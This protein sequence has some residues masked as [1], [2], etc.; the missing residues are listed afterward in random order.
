MSAGKRTPGPWIAGDS[1]VFAGP[2]M[3]SGERFQVCAASHIIMGNTPRDERTKADMAF[4]VEA[5]NSHDSLVS[6]LKGQCAELDETAAQVVTLRSQRDALAESLRFC[7]KALEVEAPI[8]KAH[9][10]E[11]RAALAIV[12]GAK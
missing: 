4:I 3:K 2:Y 1:G 10:H 12:D 6:R 5:C 8:Y 9:I 11:A 7:V